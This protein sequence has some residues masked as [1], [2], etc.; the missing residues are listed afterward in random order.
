M[1]ARGGQGRY[2]VCEHQRG[3]LAPLALVACRLRWLTRC[4]WQAAVA[5]ATESECKSWHAVLGTYMTIFFVRCFTQ[6]ICNSTRNLLKV[7]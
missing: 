2:D 6:N 7:P 5:V 1:V 3:P 4:Q